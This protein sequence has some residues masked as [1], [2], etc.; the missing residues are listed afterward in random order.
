MKNTGTTTWT[1]SGNYNLGSQNPQDNATWGTGRIGLPSSVAAGAEVTFNFTVT[2]PATPGTYNFQWRMVQ[3]G[4]EWFGDYSPNFQVTVSSAQVP[5]PR[6]GHANLTYEETNNRITTAGFEYDAAGN[7]VRA[8]IPGGTGS[9]RYQYD[10]A[11]R[12]VNVKADAGA[13]I[14]THIYGDDNQRL[15]AEEFAQ[16]TSTRT[17]HV[18]EGL[19]VI[20]EYVESGGSTTPAW[21]KSYV[22]LGNRLLSTLTPNGSGGE[23]IEYH[24]PD[25]LGTRLV[26]NPSTGGSFEQVALPFGTALNSESTGATN[27]RFTSYERS[28]TTKLDYAVNRHYDPQQGRF[29]QVDPIGMRSAQLLAPQT[30][31]LFAYCINDPINQIDPSGL[32]FLS[33]IAK[34]FRAVKKVLKWVVIAIGVALAVVFTFAALA[35]PGTQFLAGIVFKGLGLLLKFMAKYAIFNIAQVGSASL[36]IG[37]T[38]Q[39]LAGAMTV[40]AIANHLQQNQQDKDKNNDKDKRPPKERALIIA[41]EKT[42]E[43]MYKQCVRQQWHIFNQAVEKVRDAAQ[44]RAD[45]R[46]LI[47]AVGHIPPSGREEVAS[48]RPGMPR[49]GD[50]DYTTGPSPHWMEK[51]KNRAGIRRQAEARENIKNCKRPTNF[52]SIL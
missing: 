6:D 22:Y 37:L 20:A 29:T 27:R 32:G 50:I 31:N 35:L 21:S 44:Q 1:S 42:P 9:Q 45:A 41:R 51:R 15:I 52:V 4:V 26:T 11:N 10:A 49:P 16:G 13:V 30:F 33:F 38:G 14:A 17:Y 19:S 2:A 8:L 40:G 43:A 5:I 48:I 36:G 47:I 25:R 12:L 7:Q 39:I 18:A 28:D 3:D 46:S 24:H 23:A 34:I